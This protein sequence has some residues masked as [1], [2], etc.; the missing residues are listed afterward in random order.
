MR[1]AFI[2][3]LIVH[4]ALHLFGVAK[5]FGLATMAQLHVPIGRPLGVVWLVAALAFFACAALLIA[6]SR[7]W[8]IVGALAV[9]LSQMVIITSWRDARF[10]A[11]AN[12]I[13]LIP[14]A[15]AALTA[16]PMSL[17]S[18][19][20]RE[21][22]ER[23]SH[24]LDAPPVTESEVASLPPLVQT[25]LRRTGVVGRPHVRNVRA[26]FH[27]QFRAKPDAPWMPFRSVQVN[28]FSPPSRRFFM[29]A[30]LYGVPLDAFHRY[31]GPSATM[32]VR[33]AEVVEVANARGPV[34]NQ[35][36]TVTMFNDL[37]VLAPGAIVDAGVRWDPLDARSLRATWTYGAHTIRAT[38]TF[39]GAGDLVGFVSDDRAMSADGVSFRRVPW[40]TPL[41]EHREIA[42]VRVA[43]HGVAT[44]LAPEGAIE[45]GRFDLSSLE[46]N[47]REP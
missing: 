36:E 34:M 18:Q 40:S 26:R 31:E 33:A 47:V 24:R 9:A 4:G 15:V 1:T 12:V 25:W 5:A 35:A 44:W 10:G 39:D 21:A 27:G 30:T 14:I 46:Y 29:E 23:V 19:Y 17:R 41:R 20:E 11:L 22:A 16:R 42:G 37:C 45:Y 38:L 2:A 28:T 3:L 8:W 32:V 7:A 6:S 13:A 43:H